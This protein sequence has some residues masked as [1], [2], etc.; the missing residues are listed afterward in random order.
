M[1]LARERATGFR[2]GVTVTGKGRPMTKAAGTLRIFHAKLG[3]RIPVWYRARA[4][5]KRRRRDW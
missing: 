4:L 1:S 2:R 5:R 3:A